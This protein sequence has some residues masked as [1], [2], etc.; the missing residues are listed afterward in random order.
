LQ[1]LLPWGV[2]D[3]LVLAAALGRRILRTEAA[4]LAAAAIAVTVAVVKTDREADS[5]VAVAD[6]K[7]NSA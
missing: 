5:A 3:H 7:A 2:L 1:V 6:E 4:D